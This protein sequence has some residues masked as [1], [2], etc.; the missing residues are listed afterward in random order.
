MVAFF[1]LSIPLF[2]AAFVMY[3]IVVVLDLRSHDV[4]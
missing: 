3:L 1:C 2:A 4:L